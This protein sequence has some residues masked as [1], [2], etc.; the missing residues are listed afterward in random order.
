[1]KAS[2]EERETLFIMNQITLLGWGG[3]N[4]SIICINIY[5]YHLFFP[6]NCI[7]DTEVVHLYLSDRVQM[8][9]KYQHDPEI[10]SLVLS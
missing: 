5:Y 4:I 2:S 1:M 9:I 3:L 8:S 7:F 6:L 10:L